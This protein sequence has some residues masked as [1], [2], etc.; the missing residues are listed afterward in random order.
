VAEE[1]LYLLQFSTRQ[2][3]QPRASATQIVRGKILDDG[4]LRSSF[5]NMPYRLRRQAI[6]PKF[7]QA[8]Y[9]T[10]NGA[11]SDSGGCGPTVYRLLCPRRNGDGPDMFSF[12]DQIR[13]DAVLLPDFGSLQL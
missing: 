7:T 9:T 13:N 3:T 10:E 5:H 11:G 12:A 4:A 1:E 2:M 6:A 8:V